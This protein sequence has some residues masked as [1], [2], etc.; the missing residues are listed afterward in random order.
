MSFLPMFLFAI[1]F[2]RSMYLR[3]SDSAPACEAVPAG[4]RSAAV[5]FVVCR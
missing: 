1:L 5:A 3:T 4:F 2:G